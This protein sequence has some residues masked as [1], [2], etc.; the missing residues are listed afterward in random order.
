VAPKDVTVT[1]RD[2]G[3]YKHLTVAKDWP[4]NLEA[5]LMWFE[6]VEH[7]DIV[8]AIDPVMFR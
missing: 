5:Q 3:E 6:A 8:P 7:L 1:V 4:A 2:H